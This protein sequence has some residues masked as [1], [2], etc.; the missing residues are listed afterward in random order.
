MLVFGDINVDVLARLARDLRPGDDNLVPELQ[1]LCGG[2]GANA[3]IAFARWG[4]P[5]RLLGCVGRDWFGE[6]ALRCLARERIDVSFVQQTDRALTGL[7]CIPISPDGQRTIIGSRGANA[8]T[9]VRDASWSCLDGVEAL[10]LVGYD[11][12]SAAGRRVA[13]GLLQEAA[14]RGTRVALDVGVAP[15]QQIPHVILEVTCNVTW[16][17]VSLSEAMAL[18]GKSA[19]AEVLTALENCGAGE[20]IV[21]LGA[22]GCLLR[23]PRGSWCAVPPFAVSAMDST[24][25]GDAFAA[26]YLCTRLRG[27]PAKEAALLANAAGAAAASV[28]GAGENMPGPDS[29]LRLL[30]G[31]L[32]SGEMEQARQRVVHHLEQ[33]LAKGTCSGAL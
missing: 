19:R 13:E 7:F 3:A 10:F 8:E 32:L 30:N 15:S 4:V 5:V 29:V 12:L 1:H 33:E 6:F 11:F 18:S 17:F 26:A 2:V 20:I 31:S 22:D 14:R 27:W 16:L 25:A 9:G 28:L 21:K 24:G 23:E